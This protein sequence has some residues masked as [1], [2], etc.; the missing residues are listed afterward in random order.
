MF[1]FIV[2]YFLSRVKVT[3]TVQ[4][5]EWK[6]MIAASNWLSDSVVPDSSLASLAFHYAIEKI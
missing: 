5:G 6:I 2:M 1:E 4:L 3:S